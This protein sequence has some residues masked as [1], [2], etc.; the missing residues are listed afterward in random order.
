[1]VLHVRMFLFLTLTAGILKL[2]L[3]KSMM[4]PH[5]K[6]NDGDTPLHLACRVKNLKAVQLLVREPR[7][8]PLEKNSRGDTALHEACRTRQYFS[9]KARVCDSK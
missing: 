7:Y 5:S 9:G 2:L 6:N 8:N 4:D 1:M 3:E